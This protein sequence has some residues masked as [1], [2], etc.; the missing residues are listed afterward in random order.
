MPDTPFLKLPIYLLTADTPSDEA[1]QNEWQLLVASECSSTI[2]ENAAQYF[3]PKNPNKS[4]SLIE[5]AVRLDPTNARLLELLSDLYAYVA[6]KELETDIYVSKSVSALEAYIYKEENTQR[7]ITAI[8]RLAELA[9]ESHN[10]P[11]AKQSVAL[12]LELSQAKLESKITIDAIHSL[13]TTRGLIFLD[14]GNVSE[15]V[16]ALESSQPIAKTPVFSSFGPQFALANE[17][18]KL[19]EKEAV[20]IYLNC[21]LKVWKNGRVNIVLW[22]L[23]I[24]LGRKPV[25][26]T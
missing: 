5:Q 15:A 18:L 21:C 16:K 14:E 8:A 10:L 17:L 23:E 26:R 9:R 2:L 11:L 1:I 19:G 6:A 4:I 7:K 25:L 3:K 22:L 20:C 24:K 12:G 13:Q